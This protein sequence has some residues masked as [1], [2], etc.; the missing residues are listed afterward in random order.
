[1][2]N[3]HIFFACLMLICAVGV[4]AQT[5][6]P[7]DYAIQ[8]RAEVQVSPPQVKVVWPQGRWD[9][10]YT[11]S[12]K[13][14]NESSWQFLADLPAAAS[15][16]TDNNVLR[17]QGYEYQLRKT[18]SRGFPGY[19]YIYAGIELPLVE[20]RGKVILVVDETHAEQLRLELSRLRQDLVGDGWE[21][22]R[23]DVSPSDRAESIKPVIETIYN[24]DR[25]N[26]K[27]VILIGNIPVIYSGNISPD[28]HKH[29]GAWPADVYYSD[30]SGKAQWTD[31]TVHSLVA[32]R[33]INKNSPGDGKYDQSHSAGP[34]IL[35]TGRVDF[36]GLPAFAQSDPARS[37]LDL[38]RGYLNKHHL[39]RHG[40]K[41]VQRKGIIAD[42]L[43]KGH[44]AETTDG[45]GDPVGNSGWRNFS[46]LLGHENI[47]E[48]GQNEFFNEAANR[49]GYLWSFGSAS[50]RSFTSSPG[51]GGAED[52]AA[53]SPNVI[54]TMFGGGFY[55]DWKTENNF[56]RS[57]LGS[58]NILAT[59]Y[60]GLP[61]W[62]FHHMALGETIGFSTLVTQHNRRGGIYPPINDGAGQV[63]VTLL[64]DPTLRMHPVLPP[65]NLQR[66]S[67]DGVRL[68]W[69]ESQDS[70]VRGYHVYRSASPFGPFQRLTGSQPLASTSFTDQ[71]PAG[72]QTYMVR[73]LKLE[74]T[75][76]GTYLNPS[77]GLF[78]T[79]G[80]SPQATAPAA[81]SHLQAKAI[82]ATETVLFWQDASH[83][84]TR[85]EIERQKAGG[86]F[87]LI[88]AVEPGVTVFADRGLAP[89]TS[90]N[91]RVRAASH[92]GQSDFSN[93]ATVSTPHSSSI[94]PEAKARYLHADIRTRGN[95]TSGYGREGHYV[96]SKEDRVLHAAPAFWPVDPVIPAYARL[97]H[98]GRQNYV[99]TEW[100]DDPRALQRMPGPHER[101]AAAWHAQ[102]R[103]SLNLA[104]TDGKPHRLALYFVDWDRQGRSHT[105]EIFDGHGQ[106][107]DRRAVSS[108]GDGVY[109]LWEIQGEVRIELSRSAGPNVLLNG[110]FFDPAAGQDPN[111]ATPFSLEI[112][113]NREIRISG[114]AGSSVVLESSPDLRSWNALG[115]ATIE[116]SP[117]VWTTG[118]I[119]A[120]SSQYFRTRSP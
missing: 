31:F 55:G 19:G 108:F 68:N 100:T 58:G 62:Y 65:S 117:H 80:T 110:I 18:T 16:Y 97:T 95:W 107:L 45:D 56:L 10:G 67:G 13:L 22:L 44:I 29:Q 37:E 48:L 59:V 72:V 116:T 102:D 114:P 51:I 52:F 9:T 99:W 64:G 109:H 7:V 89:N 25:A 43:H 119:P 90:Y 11:I 1:M 84:V 113:R 42:F 39:F 105:V 17:G 74:Q 118:N 82:S 60:A 78:L 36:S 20:N 98:S 69:S 26:V 28:D 5:T 27:A 3:S 88:S 12:R 2:K 46:A 120:A 91:Y 47:V 32:E 66:V 15:S 41:P 77:Q 101:I 73:A 83:E 96:I 23:F 49:R 86:N 85:S 93:T 38:L 92:A 24:S 106:S 34:P 61:H 79:V 103:F 21:V 50:T 87:E 76:S 4:S 30:V 14:P 112:R 35:Q 75:P 111:P 63:H 8:P 33:L 104:F 40:Q 54:F 115:T 57:A 94:L 70:D 71:P 6:L 81:P 53:Q